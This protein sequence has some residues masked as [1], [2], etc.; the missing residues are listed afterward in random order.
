MVLAVGMGSVDTARAV[1]KTEE[2]LEKNH[3]TR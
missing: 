3:W 1:E 2:K